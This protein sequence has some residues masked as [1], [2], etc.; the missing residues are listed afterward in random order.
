MTWAKID[1]R[2]HGHIKVRR[3]GPAMALW[4]IALSYCADELTDGFVAADVPE[5]LLGAAGAE[6]AAK[7]QAV[8]LWDRLENGWRFHD[9]HD[10]NP[11]ADDERERRAEIAKKRSE[12]GKKGAANRWQTGKPDGNGHGNAVANASQP[13]RQTDSPVPVPVPE[14]QKQPDTPTPPSPPP[15]PAAGAP[16]A[17][18]AV[19]VAPKV[20]PLDAPIAAVFEHWRS[21]MG[22]GKRAALT[23][24]RAGKIR[25]RLREGY[26][27]PELC[28]AVDG[29]KRS[30][31]HQG[32]ND[33]GTVYD[34]IE[35]ICRDQQHVD[36]FVRKAGNVVALLRPGGA[37]VAAAPVSDDWT[38]GDE[39]P[40]VTLLR[41]AETRRSGGAA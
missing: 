28:R 34:D 4:V 7:L 11:N 30:P 40:L 15:Q 36:M 23:A 18:P 41:D 33:G 35:L 17:E 32:Q 10:Y 19:V 27:A 12:A 14:P 6:M 21:V 29:C 22:K 39:D 3:A 2:L 8:G 38:E 25:G 9:Y 20:D 31:H 16:P 26:T 24:K 1:D 5:L 13:P 37:R